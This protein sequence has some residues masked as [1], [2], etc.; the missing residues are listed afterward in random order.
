MASEFSN[1]ASRGYLATG[2]RGLATSYFINIH[3]VS[4]TPLSIVGGDRN[5]RLTGPTAC[6]FGLNNASSF[7]LF[8]S[9][10]DLWTNALHGLRGHILKM[11]GSVLETTSRQFQAAFIL[12]EG[13]N[14]NVSPHLLKA[15]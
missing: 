6:V 8:G 5:L 14:D 12:S 11:D 9:G 4:A 13:N 7:N 10:T 15:R 1:D 3:S 2:F